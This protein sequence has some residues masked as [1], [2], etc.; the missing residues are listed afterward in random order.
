MATPGMIVKYINVTT[1]QQATLVCHER[2]FLIELVEKLMLK[3]SLSTAGLLGPPMRKSMNST[4]CQ[5]L[6]QLYHTSLSPQRY[7][8]HWD[9]MAEYSSSKWWRNGCWKNAYY[10]A[11]GMF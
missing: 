10:S 4:P 8:L 11:G 3:L 9:V 1:M 6:V 5:L 2:I 7:R